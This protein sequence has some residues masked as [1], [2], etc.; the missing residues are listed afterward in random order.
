MAKVNPS[1]RRSLKVEQ[2]DLDEVFVFDSPPAETGNKSRFRR[3]FPNI[4][5]TVR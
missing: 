5:H 1:D 3:T 2:N 4:L